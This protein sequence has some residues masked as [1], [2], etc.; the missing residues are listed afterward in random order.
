MRLPPWQLN[1]TEALAHLQGLLQNDACAR[2]ALA[3]PQRAVV[4]H[5]CVDA[6]KLVVLVDR[7][8][9]LKIGSTGWH[10]LALMRMLKIWRPP[11]SLVHAMTVLV[12]S[13]KPLVDV[14]LLFTSKQ[15]DTG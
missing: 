11:S 7:S 3:A 13:S 10:D 6:C 14:R 15:F 2:E 9:L 5:L 1:L 4:V 12:A 8:T